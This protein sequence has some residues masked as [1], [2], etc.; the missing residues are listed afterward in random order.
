MNTARCLSRRPWRAA[1]ALAC[2]C[3]FG[4]AGPA[5]F[6]QPVP[7]ADP[8]GAF[9][10]IGHI[11]RFTLL[12]PGVRTSAARVTVRGI[13]VLLPV[14]LIITMP[15]G[16][17][18]AE[19]LFRGRDFRSPSNPPRSGLALADLRDADL[20]CPPPLAAAGRRCPLPAAEIELAGNIVRGEY[21]AGIARISQGA[22]H[23]G[24]GFIRGIDPVTGF[25][26]VGADASTGPTARLR[27]ND[28]EGIYGPKPAAGVVDMR[29]A[30]D[31]GNA[32]VH[33][34]TGFPVC[35]PDRARPGVCPASNRPADPAAAGYRRYTCGTEAVTPLE[36]A[37]P[38]CRPHLPAPLRVGDYVNYVGMLD[39]DARGYF[40]SVHG[41][42]AELGIYTS[43]GVDPAY[44]FV[45]EALQGTLGA[46]YALDALN[47][48]PQ[49]ETSR[50]KIVGFTSD[51]SRTVDVETF[52]DDTHEGDLAPTV[53]PQRL[54]TRIVPTNLAQL[55]R[56]KLIWSAKED[57]R[58]VRRNVRV[59]LSAAT[60]PSLVSQ[61]RPGGTSRDLPPGLRAAGASTRGGYAYGQYESPVSEFIAPEI[62]RFGV[63]GWPVPFNFEDFCFHRTINR[64]DTQE[65]AAGGYLRLTVGPLAPSPANPAR[66]LS[67]QKADGSR[68]CDNA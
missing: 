5:A 45:E 44:V 24:G 55:G 62:T 43:P 33:A 32:P 49:E 23:I 8:P 60:R 54:A 1:L 57:A 59:V 28:P 14:N 34:R 6:A 56:F 25:F 22:L 61:L 63:K 19:Q 18:S 65:P 29:F 30:L 68:V 9:T 12:S 31:P 66:P 50:Y 17:L 26:T 67:Q 38:G 20:A 2:C 11:E 10:L 4:G 42:D 52:D 37:L 7:A 21:V 15:G 58:I 64:I 13:D 36:P 39:K 40:V 27:L 41:L 46:R 3:L 47:T 35:L 16:Y 53:A 48:L 51:P